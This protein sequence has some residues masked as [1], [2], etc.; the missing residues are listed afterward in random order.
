[1]MIAILA[2]ARVLTLAD[3]VTTA[4]KNQPQL[5]QA[6]AN[7]LAAGARVDEA[8]APL[9]PQL[10]GSAVYYRRTANFAPT[11]GA[12]PKSAMN[13]T[14]YSWDTVNY[15]SLGL[16]LN[17]MVWDF[18][19]VDLW[20][21]KKEL[22]LW[23]ADTERYTRLQVDMTVRTA[24]F[25]ARAQK[26]LVG[27]ARETLENQTKHLEQIEGFVKVGTQPEIALA[28][29]KTNLA[30]AQ[31]QVIST[32][33]AYETAKATLNQAM[34]IE[35]DTDYDVAEDEL[36]AVDGEDQKTDQL[37]SE[38]LKAR[39]D[40]A[41]LLDQ[42]GAQKLVLRS[43]KGGYGPLIA[44]GSA[45]TD[46][47]SDITN[48]AWNWN[49]NASVS[50]SLFSGLSTYSTVKEQHYNELAL[51]AQ[52]D[53]LKQQVRL[54]VEQAR[55]AVRGAKATLGASET[56][57][58]NAREQLRLAE[59]RYQAGVGSI[60]ELSDAQVALTTAAAQRVSA[61]YGLATARAQLL[62]ALGR[63]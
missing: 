8:R 17:Q 40:V 10:S 33:N 2:V 37:L 62:R 58:I 16:Q 63:K 31:V 51:V 59:G 38:A 41:S 39:P 61:D 24:F 5:A 45:L 11:P 32:E 9:L 7:T 50:W 3:A 35:Q 49:V 60:I 23:G 14:A 20:K 57:L 4:E 52:L 44:V 54:D 15:I 42:V 18:Q 36:A 25:N 47:G 27:V 1:M 26:A 56:A 6:R 29:A 22:H 28:Q 34:G 13:T 43:A 21:S 48:L 55:L 30:N 46:A 12:V 19:T 53:G